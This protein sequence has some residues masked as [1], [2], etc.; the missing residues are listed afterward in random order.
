M[1]LFL[2]TLGVLLI[3]AGMALAP[4]V[5]T[6]F[7]ATSVDNYVLLAWTSGAETGVS[8][9]QLERSLDGITFQT[10]NSTSPTGSNSS[11]LYEDHGLYKVTS[12]TYFYRINV[13]MENGSSSY[14]PVA[15]LS[16][17]FSGIQQTWGSIKSLFR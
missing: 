7:T 6:E 10:I 2:T 13:V 16:L 15:Q 9:Y 1:K 4:S 5:I 3:F 14:S 12:R 11:Y 17:S 8:V